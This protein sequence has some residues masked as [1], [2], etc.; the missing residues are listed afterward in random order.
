MEW[1]VTQF[2]IDLINWSSC[3]PGSRIHQEFGIPMQLWSLNSLRLP[4]RIR[5]Y[6]CSVRKNE[7]FKP[8]TQPIPRFYRVKGRE[9]YAP[10]LLA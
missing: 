4:K 1:A 10:K 7:L 2:P 6:E 9:D 5:S 3:P 8:R